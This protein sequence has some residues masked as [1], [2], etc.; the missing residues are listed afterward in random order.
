MQEK[1][2]I[3]G[4]SGFWGKYLFEGLKKDFDVYGSCNKTSIK[5]K[6][7]FRLNLENSE[8]IHNTFTQIKPNIIIHTAACSK[9]DICENNKEIAYRINV[10][11]TEKI[12]EWCKENN[13]RLIFFSTDL[14]YDSKNPEILFKE[15]D[16]TSPKCY[17]AYTKLTAEEKIRNI[18]DECIILRV[19]LSYGIGDNMHKSFFDWI[20]K[21][22]SENKKVTLFTDQYRTPMFVEEGVEIIKI[23]I[24]NR[25]KN[26]TINFGGIEKLNRYEFGLKVTEVFNFS[27]ELLKPIKSTEAQGITFRSFNSSMNIEKLIKLTDYRFNT[28]QENLKRIKSKISPNEAPH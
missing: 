15:S 6:K 13:C 14:V 4:A 16:K 21:N 2:F 19:A 8:E 9:V 23:L 12:A 18:L 22:L 28:I 17:Y 3:T 11:A 1:I 24:K 10:E 27:K 26:E 5:N 25:I 7:I 20:Y